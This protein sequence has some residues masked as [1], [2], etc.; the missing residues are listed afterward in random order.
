MQG[1]K[2]PHAPPL[3]TG[4]VSP[5]RSWVTIDQ[6]PQF[7]RSH[8]K[9]TAGSIPLIA[10]LAV[11][12]KDKPNKLAFKQYDAYTGLLSAKPVQVFVWLLLKN[13]VGQFGAAV[14]AVD[15]SAMKCEVCFAL[16]CQQSAKVRTAVVWEACKRK[17]QS[18]TC[19]SSFPVM[20]YLLRSMMHTMD[21]EVPL[22]HIRAPIG[23]RWQEST[24]YS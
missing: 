13:R 19:P 17:C 14:S 5:R 20:L 23:N 4:L 6:C 7:E 22:L 21:L 9:Y 16:E 15:V 18:S 11:K 2:L 8:P 3:V 1:A 12:I 24:I 10:I